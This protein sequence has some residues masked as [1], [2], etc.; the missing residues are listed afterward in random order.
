MNGGIKVK[1][2]PTQMLLHHIVHLSQHKSMLMLE[3]YDIK[4]WQAGI[5][6]TLDNQGGLSQR[7][8]AKM[9]RVTPPTMTVAIKKMERQGYITREQDAND[10]RIIRLSITE[11]GRSCITEAKTVFREL[12]DILLIGI[13]TEEKL[14]LRRLLIQMQE[15]MAENLK[16]SGAEIC[17]H[18]H[19]HNHME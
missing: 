18:H 9:T 6:F 7:E 17:R 14:L 8:L 13:S 4:P 5:L 12:E 11:K 15:N 3:Q 16:R 1:V 10:Q 19:G 2:D